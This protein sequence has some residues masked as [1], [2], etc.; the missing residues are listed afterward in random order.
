MSPFLLTVSLALLAGMLPATRQ[1]IFH[2]LCNEY[3]II[4]LIRLCAEPS[5][6]YRGKRSL[7]VAGPQVSDGDKG[8]VS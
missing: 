4:Q 2:R 8:K 3:Y 7:S 6:A 5:T 1:E